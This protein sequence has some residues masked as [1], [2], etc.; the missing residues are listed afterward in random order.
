MRLSTIRTGT[1]GENLVVINLL[2]RGMDVYKPCVDDKTIDLLVLIDRSPITIQ[3]KNHGSY[4]GGTSLQV[5]V[6]S[7]SADIIAVPYKD[8]V[9]YL[10]N[11]RKNQ[12]WGVTLCVKKPKNNQKIKVRFAEDYEEFPLYDNI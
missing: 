9:F 3:V 7:T 5:R 4:R 6:K 2:K 1:I 11:N 8:R 10:N 12:S